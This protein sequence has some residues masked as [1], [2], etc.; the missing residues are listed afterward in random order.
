MIRSWPIRFPQWRVFYGW[1]IVAAGSVIESVASGLYWYGFTIFF[2]P[3]SRELGVSRASVSL[4]FSGSRLQ[5]AVEGPA[6]GWLVDK[7]GP[8]PLILVGALLAGL[9]Y[10]AM[11]QVHSFLTLLL[12]YLL[13]VSIGINAG[14][15]SP[16]TAAINTWFIRNKSMA[17]SVASAATGLGAAIIVP[18]LSFMIQEW[19]WRTAALAGGLLIWA[20]SLPCA[21]VMHRSP[22]SRGMHPDGRPPTQPDAGAVRTPRGTIDFTTG[23]G[24]RTLAYWQLTMAIALRMLVTTAVTIHMVPMMVWK[25]IPE[26]TAAI[27]VSMLALGGIPTRLLFGWLGIRHNQAILSGAGT[28]FCAAGLLALILSQSASGVYAFIVLMMFSEGAILC[29]WSLIGDFFG[30]RSFATLLGLMGPVHSLATFA[31]PIF[32]GWVYDKTDS[33]TGALI[34]FCVLSGAAGLTF[35]LLRRPRLPQPEGSARRQP[36]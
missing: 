5:T 3:L 28:L 16:V 24:L 1:K 36:T 2:L 32:A 14:F 12:V 20:V 30:R 8:R 35:F 7:I 9:G 31:S 11:T 6:V 26:T 17:L 29:N 10:V 27:L 34:T 23:Q 19:G 4:L 13:L 25:G 21:L 15:W 33:Y 22:E 18:L